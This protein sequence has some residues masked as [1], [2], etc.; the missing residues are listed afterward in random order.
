[1]CLVNLLLPLS[2]PPS[3]YDVY[4]FSHAQQDILEPDEDPLK[5]KVRKNELQAQRVLDVSH[6][7]T[8]LNLIG[9]SH[10]SFAYMYITEIE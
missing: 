8:G 6:V 10:Y 5:A 3:S 1:M 9:P 7:T 2:L 4:G